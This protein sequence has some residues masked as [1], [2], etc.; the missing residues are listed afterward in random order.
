MSQSSSLHCLLFDLYN[1]VI[2]LIPNISWATTMFISYLYK[3]SFHINIEYKST[4]VSK[5]KGR[6]L[7]YSSSSVYSTHCVIPDMAN[8]CL[9]TLFQEE[10]G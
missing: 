9:K 6:F 8:D 5:C 10:L 2:F 1:L 3:P 7:S 4:C